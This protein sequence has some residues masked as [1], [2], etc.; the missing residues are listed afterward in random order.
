MHSALLAIDSRRFEAY[1]ARLRLDTTYYGV[2]WL[3]AEFPVLMT[4]VSISLHVAV[5]STTMGLVL[6]ASKYF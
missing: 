2:T 1:S 4:A 6:V 5:F 3:L